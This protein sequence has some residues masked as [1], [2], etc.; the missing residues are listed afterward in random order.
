M[1][2]TKA[3]YKMNDKVWWCL[4]RIPSEP[5]R[6]FLS[7]IYH[8]ILCLLVDYYGDMDTIPKNSGTNTGLQ[9]LCMGV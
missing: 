2:Q 3:F 1:K 6:K 9:G 8:R 4:N 7:G 5:L